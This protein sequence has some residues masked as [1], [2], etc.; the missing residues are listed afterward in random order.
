MGRT[1]CGAG[2]VVVARGT[3]RGHARRRGPMAAVDNLA[4]LAK[5][6]LICTLQTWPGRWVLRWH[7][8]P[9]RP[10]SAPKSPHIYARTRERRSRHIEQIREMSQARER[11]STAPLATGSPRPR[12]QLRADLS[13]ATPS[14]GKVY[15]GPADFTS[16][17]A[18]LRSS[19]AAI[20]GLAVS[21]RR[22]GNGASGLWARI[23]LSVR[24]PRV[25]YARLQHMVFRDTIRHRVPTKPA[26]NRQYPIPASCN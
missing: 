12:H 10:P 6:P 23:S 3:H 21:S 8:A 2:D 24:D 20:Y 13:A 19:G 11:P 26:M 16:A 22:R 9:C 7:Q 18:C 15:I 14:I 25:I 1:L 5:R 17:D 4:H